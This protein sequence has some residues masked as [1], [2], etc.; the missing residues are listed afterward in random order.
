MEEQLWKSG[1]R[2]WNTRM[3]ERR[4]ASDQRR[5]W[6]RNTIAIPPTSKHGGECPAH[7]V[8]KPATLKKSKSFIDLTPT[9]L[10]TSGTLR[11]AR[12]LL[13]FET[14]LVTTTRSA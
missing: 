13:G 1:I 8:L 14:S 4:R 2:A 3:D 12:N 6:M 9:S 10:Q 11:F 5:D 7:L